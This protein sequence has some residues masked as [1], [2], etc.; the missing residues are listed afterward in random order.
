MAVLRFERR[1]GKLPGVEERLSTLLERIDRGRREADEWPIGESTRDAI[2]DL[3]A[4]GYIVALT[5]ESRSRRLDER[6][7]SL[8][9]ELEDEEAAREARRLAV[10]KRTLDSRVRDLRE[11]LADLRDR[12]RVGT[13]SSPRGHAH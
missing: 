13:P 5:C 10:Q 1:Q 7:R 8:V 3:L 9:E 12:L 4:E 2:E 11:R 6:L